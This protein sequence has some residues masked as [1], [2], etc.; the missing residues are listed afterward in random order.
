MFIDTES[1]D[2]LGT[3]HEKQLFLSNE[4]IISHHYETSPILL[5]DALIPNIPKFEFLSN[6]IPQKQ[7]ITQPWQ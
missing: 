6:E 3:K 2:A 7:D 4:A 5:W 1:Q